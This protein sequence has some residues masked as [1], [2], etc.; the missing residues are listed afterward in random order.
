MSKVS[1]YQYLTNQYNQMIE[2][3]TLPAPG[4]NST[5]FNL[6]TDKNIVS[7]YP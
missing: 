1:V 4:A 3:G 5:D 2:A 7:T 6:T